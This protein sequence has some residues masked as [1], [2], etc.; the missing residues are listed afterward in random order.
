MTSLNAAWPLLAFVLVLLAIPLALWAM[1]RAGLGG[2]GPE[3]G[4]AHV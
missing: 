2:T 3:I 4:R 1:K